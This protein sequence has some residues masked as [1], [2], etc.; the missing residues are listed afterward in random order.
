AR[1]HGELVVIGG[2]RVVMR[3][4]VVFRIPLVDQFLLQGT[5]LFV[6]AVESLLRGGSLCRIRT[7]TW[8]PSSERCR[9]QKCQRSRSPSEHGCP[10]K[11]NPSKAQL[12]TPEPRSCGRV[13]SVRQ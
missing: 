8:A 9:H 4:P 7:L 3:H 12:I 2:L 10:P 13:P 11:P 5:Q 1:R 6:G